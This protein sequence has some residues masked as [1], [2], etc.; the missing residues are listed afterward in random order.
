MKYLKGHGHR[1]FSM[2]TI[3]MYSTLHR[4]AWIDSNHQRHRS[5]HL[6]HEYKTSPPLEA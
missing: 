6:Y 5:P 3:A 1:Y 4:L 2:A